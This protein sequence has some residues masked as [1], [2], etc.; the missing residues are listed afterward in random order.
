M[1]SPFHPDGTATR[2]RRAA[3]CTRSTRPAKGA[4][5]GSIPCGIRQHGRSPRSTERPVIPWV[6]ASAR[7]G[8]SLLAAGLVVAGAGV[9]RPA[10]LVA[11]PGEPAR[12]PPSAFVRV[13]QVG[14]ARLGPKRAYLMSAVGEPGGRFAVVDGHDHTALSGPVGPGLGSWSARFPHVYAIDF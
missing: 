11:G 12:T 14:Y 8:R 6:E 3:G 13:D 10:A 1:R 9:P 5:P 7:N 4:R 2:E